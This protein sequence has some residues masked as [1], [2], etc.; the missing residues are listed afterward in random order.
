MI[1]HTIFQDM[2]SGMS[3]EI[4]DSSKTI[5]DWVCFSIKKKNNNLL[6]DL[7]F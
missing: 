1:V 4:K 2:V 6:I 7:C 3:A 5:Q